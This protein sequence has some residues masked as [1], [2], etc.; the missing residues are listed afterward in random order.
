MLY[1]NGYRHMIINVII[2]PQAMWQMTNVWLA[3]LCETTIPAEGDARPVLDPGNAV[4]RELTP[5]TRTE[6]YV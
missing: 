6:P 5:Q 3:L 1:F 2:D 4:P